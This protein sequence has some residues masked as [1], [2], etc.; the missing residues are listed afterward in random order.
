MSKNRQKRKT[1]NLILASQ[2][3]ITDHEDG[4]EF[5]MI[6]VSILLHAELGSNDP[7]KNIRHL[8]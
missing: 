2:R 5:L 7:G 8:V 3:V 1:I 4:C 6:V